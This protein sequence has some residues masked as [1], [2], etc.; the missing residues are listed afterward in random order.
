MRLRAAILAIGIALTLGGCADFDLFGDDGDAPPVATAPNG[1]GA[2]GC[3]Q[4]PQFCVARGYQPG[5]DGYNRC[6]VSVEQN[7]RKGA[8]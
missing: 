2:Q 3:P 7:L 8:Q 6:I 4:A 1:C 5:T